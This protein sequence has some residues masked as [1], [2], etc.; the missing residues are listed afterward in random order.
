VDVLDVLV[1]KVEQTD[2]DHIVD[3]GEKEQYQEDEVCCISKVLN[4]V[5]DVLLINGSS[6]NVVIPFRLVLSG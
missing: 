5:R 2:L 6:Q 3:D 1:D 4:R